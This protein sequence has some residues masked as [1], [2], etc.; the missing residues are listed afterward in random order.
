MLMSPPSLYVPSAFSQDEE[1]AQNLVWNCPT[2]NYSSHNEVTLFF[3]SFSPLET[4]FDLREMM[5]AR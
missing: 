2:Q 4:P 5:S 3:L 1:L